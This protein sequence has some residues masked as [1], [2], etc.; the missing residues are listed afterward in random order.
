MTWKFVHVG[1]YTAT[2]A[3]T[4]DE[5]VIRTRPK[6]DGWMAIN[7][8][9]DIVLGTGLTMRDAKDWCLSYDT[10]CVLPSQTCV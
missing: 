5:Y 3:N 7:E 6:G 1:Y 10:E 9:E 2:S 8:T 4:G